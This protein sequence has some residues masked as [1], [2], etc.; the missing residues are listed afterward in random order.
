MYK[1][2]QAALSPKWSPNEESFWE[3]D[4]SHIYVL[5]YAYL[6]ILVQSQILVISLYLNKNQLLKHIGMS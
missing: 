6:N 4:W 5:I 3:K 2:D 1:S